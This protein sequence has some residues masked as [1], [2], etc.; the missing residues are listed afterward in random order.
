MSYKTITDLI[1]KM[2]VPNCLVLYGT[3]EYFIDEA[4]KLTKHKYVE[5]NYESMNYTEFEKI[6]N[7]F[8][9]FYEFVTTFPFMSQKKLCVVRD[10]G[11]LTSSGSLGK[12]EEEQLLSFID[13]DFDSCITIFL[14]KGG[15]PD[16]RKKIVKK[17]KDKAIEVN[18]L[19]ETELTKY[20][21][22]MFKKY[23]LTISIKEADYMA[24]NC[25]YL[26]YEST[27]SLYHVNNEIDKIAS[28]N[29]DAK[30]ISMDDIDKL[31]IKSVESN[32]FKLVDFICE[33]NKKR[34]F[35]ILEEMLLNNT[36]EQFIIHMIARQYRMIYHYVVLQKNGYTFNEIMTTMKL[37]NFIATK[38]SKQ[39]K[40]LNIKQIEIYMEKFLEIDKKI[41]TGE[42]DSRIGL[43]IITNGI[44]K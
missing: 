11:F 33:G 44:I 31:M 24:N 20:I 5:E 39:A 6:E 22:N 14:I 17:L 37:K 35:D 38:L 26:E 4:V 29:K 19:N 27:V 43:E 1:D 2:N 15:K 23:N 16:L 42:L 41:K 3:E 34:A 8:V 40:N 25:G 36:S 21:V 13:N 30:N 18:K 32:I 7:S 10:A 12:K 28:Y 9:E